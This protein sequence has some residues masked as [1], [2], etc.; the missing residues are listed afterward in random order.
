MNESGD[1]RSHRRADASTETF[2]LSTRVPEA[3]P[4][5]SRLL[6]KHEAAL[7]VLRDSDEKGTPFVLYLRKFDLHHVHGPA[8]DERQS[9]EEMLIDALPEGA[10]MLAVQESPE[11]EAIRSVWSPRVP[12]LRFGEADDWQAILRPI[13]YRAEL[14]VSEFVFLSEGVRWEL[15]TCRALGKH[16]QTVLLLPP[17]R[18]IYEPL[19]H[20]VP[21]DQFPRVLW[22]NQLFTEKLAKSLVME[23]LLQRVAS[24]ARLPPDER[25]RL[26]AEGRLHTRVPLSYESVLAG[27]N[28]RANDWEA[29][30]ALQDDG[31]VDYYR[32]WDWFRKAA[33]LGVLIREF[34][35][36]SLEEALFD[37]A[38]SYIMVLQGIGHH[39]VPVGAPGSFLTTELVEKLASSLRAM[40]DKMPNDG[41]ASPIRALA[42]LTLRRLGFALE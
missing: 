36:L 19:D 6:A 23:D 4:L 37:L 12:S 32:F 39:V 25:L 15:E 29:R 38:Y 7:S 9:G 27:Y 24:I 34:K 18:S 13:I 28:A 30:A 2:G 5:D 22:V 33:I 20:L 17:P 10:R 1:F 21:L 3:L 14:I 42:E 40:L 41:R 31:S 26:L 11:G 35:T 8:D 16:H